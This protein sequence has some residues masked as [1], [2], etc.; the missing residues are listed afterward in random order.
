MQLEGIKVLGESL[1]LVFSGLLR[2]QLSPRPDG[3][4]RLSANLPRREGDA[5]ERAMARTERAIPGDRRTRERRDGDR[6]LLVAERALE[7]IDAARAGR[8]QLTFFK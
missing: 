1:A 2:L 4:M 7:A 8:A 3:V 5:L 6:L